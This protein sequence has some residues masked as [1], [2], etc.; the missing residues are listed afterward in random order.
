MYKMVDISPETWNEVAVAAIKINENDDVNKIRKL[1][2]YISDVS[3]RWEGKN[4]YDLIDKEIE[5]KYG[6]KKMSG[7]TNQQITKYKIDRARFVKGS[8]H[9]MSVNGVI[10]IPILMQR[11]LSDSKTIKFRS[12][13]GFN[14][15][16]LILKKEQSVLI[17][18]L[19]AFS[20]KNRAAAQSL[21]KRKSKH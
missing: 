12:D 1:F 2:L 6:A 19:K 18:L 5:R 3:K 20:V 16:N 17:P 4:L 21:R 13:L 8:K 7:L 11:R 15:I 14:Q 9:S 10:L